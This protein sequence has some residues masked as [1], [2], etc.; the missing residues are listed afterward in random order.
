MDSL[1]IPMSILVKEYIRITISWLHR[2]IKRSSLSRPFFVGWIHGGF[3]KFSK[4]LVEEP[5]CGGAPA[6]EI[7]FL[8]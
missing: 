3:R 4:F 5:S 1:L 6:G 7:W 8:V 2:V